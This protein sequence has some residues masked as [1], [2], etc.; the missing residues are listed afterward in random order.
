MKSN[1]VASEAFPLGIIEM[2][3][4]VPVGPMMLTSV[5]QVAVGLASRLR[6]HI[7]AVMAPPYASRI[8]FPLRQLVVGVRFSGVLST[9][10]AHK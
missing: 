8:L 7:D 4:G 3:A 2:W 6:S 9:A 1:E 5:F 10:R